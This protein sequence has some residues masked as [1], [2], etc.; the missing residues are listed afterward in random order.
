MQS[1]QKRPRAKLSGLND[2]RIVPYV[3]IAPFVIYLLGVYL[4]PT[5]STII[6]SF[7]RIDGPNA[8]EFI[9]LSNYNKLL[10]KNYIMAL[11]T[12]ALFTV[13]DVAILIPVPLL[14]A[15]MLASKKAPMPNFFKSLYFIPALQFFLSLFS[16]H[17]HRAELIYFESS[18]VTSDSHL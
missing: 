15:A 7:Q 14:F 3:M 9:G 8:A 18:A 2:P 5:I 4:Y 17:I 13:W 16:I 12:T 6:M 10:T 1:A 11:K